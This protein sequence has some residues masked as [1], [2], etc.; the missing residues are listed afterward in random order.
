MLDPYVPHRG[1]TGQHCRA[2]GCRSQ[3]AAHARASMC[4]LLLCTLS[5]VLCSSMLGT[6]SKGT[7]V[8][9]TCFLENGWHRAFF[10]NGTLRF[11]FFRDDVAFISPSLI[12]SFLKEFYSQL[13]ATGHFFSKFYV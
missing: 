4:T 2:A 9:L 8:R 5:L 12:G 6:S 3:E 1:A 13:T 7:P 10:V 11:L